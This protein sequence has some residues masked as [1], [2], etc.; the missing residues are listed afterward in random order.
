MVWQYTPCAVCSSTP[1]C[2]PAGGAA[3]VPLGHG[4]DPTPDTQPRGHQPLQAGVSLE[5]PSRPGSLSWRTHGLVVPAL[6]LVAP[7]DDLAQLNRIAQVEVVAVDHVR[8]LSH[9]YLNL[10][11]GPRS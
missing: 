6:G 4:L 8:V 2:S 10:R 3:L 9:G 7:L 11:A 1:A 5:G